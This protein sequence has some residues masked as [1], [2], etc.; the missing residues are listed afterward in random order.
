MHVL[1][2]NTAREYG[3]AIY[4][5]DI[6]GTHTWPPALDLPSRNE[7]FVQFISNETSQIKSLDM[8]FEGNNAGRSGS[9][10]YGG[11]LNKCN[12]SHYTLHL[13]TS[14]V[15]DESNDTKLAAISS[16]PVLCFC[17]EGRSHEHECNGE[18]T[19]N[20]YSGQKINVSGVSDC[21]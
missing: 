17:T 2:K 10:L 5:I 12:D 11:M 15:K 4:V 8:S 3:G 18:K 7:C 13:F 20:A 6:T 21:S 9:A 1:K 16:D 14:S 19:I